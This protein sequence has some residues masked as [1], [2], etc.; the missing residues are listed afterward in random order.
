MSKTIIFG[1]SGFVGTALMKI[2]PEHVGFSSQY[3]D[4]SKHDSIEKISSVVEDGDSVVMLAVLTQEKG[5]V[6]DTTIRNIIMARNIIAGLNGK[7]INHFVYVSSDSVYGKTWE[8]IDQTTPVCPDTLY[9]YMH[10][11]REQYFKEYFPTLTILRPCAIYGIGDTHNSYGVNRFVRDAKK[12]GAI[13]LFG[14]GEEYRSNIHVDDVVTIIK[15]ALDEKISGTFNAVNGQ[16]WRFSEVANFIQEN[17][18]K[19][20]Q[21]IQTPRTQPITHRHFDNK[22]LCDTFLTPRTLD[23]GVREML[24]SSIE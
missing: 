7:K 4:L 12:G 3:M 10:A 19:S 8:N 2:L 20:I 18:G 16:S 23:I 9:G 11:L 1:S 15:K 22:A 24:E 21:I 5:D 17:I 6:R 13:T 14:G